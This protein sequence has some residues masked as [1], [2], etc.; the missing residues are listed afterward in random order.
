M[1]PKY[2]L[3]YPQHGIYVLYSSQYNK[4]K[5]HFSETEGGGCRDGIIKK[6]D[7]YTETECHS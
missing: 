5:N 3:L 6:E 2:T 4:W 1:E 7:A